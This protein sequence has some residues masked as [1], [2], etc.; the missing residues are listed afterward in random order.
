MSEILEETNREERG[1][2]EGQGDNQS[3]EGHLQEHNESRYRGN[4]H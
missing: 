3:S 4:L 1:L 2:P